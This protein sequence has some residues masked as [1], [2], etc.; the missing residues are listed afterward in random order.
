MTIIEKPKEFTHNSKMLFL[1]QIE[2]AQIFGGFII[3]FL[4]DGPAFLVSFLSVFF[5]PW[6]IVV[7]KMNVDKKKIQI[8]LKES[9]CRCVCVENLDGIE[10][11]I[12]AESIDNYEAYVLIRDIENIMYRIETFSVQIDWTRSA[13]EE[14]FI[15]TWD[16]VFILPTIN[17]I[18][19]PALSIP[20]TYICEEMKGVVTNG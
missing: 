7:V 18:G 11:C 3:T 19:R 10:Q 1:T 17:L 12:I 4:L 15:T 2:V 14:I 13:E 9:Q 16:N 8:Y 5:I 6:F 20:N